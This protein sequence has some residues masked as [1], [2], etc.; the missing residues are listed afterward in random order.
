MNWIAMSIIGLVAL[1]AK[2]SKKVTS[3]GD[4]T[5]TSEVG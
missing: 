5:G 3:N 1:K 2:K 4:R